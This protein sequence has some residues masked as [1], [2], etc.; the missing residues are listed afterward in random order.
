MSDTERLIVAAVGAVL[1]AAL[2][3]SVAPAVTAWAQSTGAAAPCACGEQGG[4][5][6]VPRAWHTQRGKAQSGAD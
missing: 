5:G 6:R 2:W 4:G 3:P 1:V